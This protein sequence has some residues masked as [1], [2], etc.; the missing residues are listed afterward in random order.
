MVTAG[1]KSE[2]DCFL[3]GK[4]D[5]PR[6]YVEKQRHHFVNKGPYGQG[7]GLSSSHVQL[8]EMDNKEGRAL[9]NWCF[10]TVVL[11]K[12]LESPLGR[13]EIKSVNLKGNQ[14]WI[15]FEQ[16]DAEAEASILWPHHA[17][18]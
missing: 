2:D 10:W 3:A 6:Q 4:Y 1:M 13:E 18:S 14:L 16:T 9:K 17:K 5:K 7:C 8:W 15:A 12:T 11:K